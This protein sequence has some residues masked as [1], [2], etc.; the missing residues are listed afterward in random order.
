M[1]C[2]NTLCNAHHLRELTNLLEEQGQAWA[3]DMIESLTHASHLGNINC[4]DG[5]SPNYEAQKYRATFRDLRH[6][7]MTPFWCKRW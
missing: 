1:L 6:L 2:Q 5:Q 3:G 7:N 4:A